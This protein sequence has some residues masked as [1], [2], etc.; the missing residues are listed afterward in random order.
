VRKENS[1]VFWLPDDIILNTQKAFN[2]SVAN[3]NTNNGYGT[4]FGT[5]GPTGRF[6]APAGYGNC[7]SRYGGECGFAN[8]IVYGPSFFK[9]DAGLSK[10]IQFGERFKIELRATALDLLNHPNFRIGGFAADTT[11]ATDRGAAFG[12]LANGSAY[13]DTS[14]T[15]DPGGRVIDLMI[16]INW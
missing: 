6:I 1:L 12:Q 4:T 13:Q 2:I 15:N 11:A 3:T 8:L 7:I 10:Q 5:G 16:R 9:I 14:T